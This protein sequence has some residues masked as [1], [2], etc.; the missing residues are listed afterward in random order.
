MEIVNAPNKTKLTPARAL[1]TNMIRA[2]VERPIA[3]AIVASIPNSASEPILIAL[4]KEEALIRSRDTFDC[5]A[6]FTVTSDQATLLFQ[7][8][9]AIRNEAT[10]ATT[11]IASNSNSEVIRRYP[12]KDL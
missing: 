9:R 6:M 2:A 7:V 10:A 1:R 5:P 8:L 3:S 4:A 12:S 11:K